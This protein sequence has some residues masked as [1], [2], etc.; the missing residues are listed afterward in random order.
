MAAGPGRVSVHTWPGSIV[1]FLPYKSQKIGTLRNGLW[2][3]EA[4]TPALAAQEVRRPPK[5]T[6]KSAFGIKPPWGNLYSWCLEVVSLLPAAFPTVP[7]V[8]ES[9]PLMKEQPTHCS[10]PGDLHQCKQRL[11][12]S[13]AWAFFE[14]GRKRTSPL[15]ARLAY[16]DLKDR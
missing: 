15:S 7:G 14:Q 3:R 13:K 6:G 16:T 10:W 8:P 11:H 9:E 1:P 4:G 5:G 12:S 2:N